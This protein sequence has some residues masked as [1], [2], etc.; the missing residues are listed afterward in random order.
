MWLDPIQVV[1]FFED[2]IQWI[3]VDLISH[4]NIGTSAKWS[5]SQAKEVL[6]KNSWVSTLLE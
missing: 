6:S 4:L 2:V 5:P 1:F 3:N